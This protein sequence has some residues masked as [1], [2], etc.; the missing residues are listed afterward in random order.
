MTPPYLNV[1]LKGP[2][3]LLQHTV[4][5]L[6]CQLHTVHS[7]AIE[8]FEQVGAGHPREGKEGQTITIFQIHGLLSDPTKNL[9]PRQVTQIP[10][11]SMGKQEFRVFFANL[12]NG[13]GVIKSVN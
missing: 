3:S 1:E 5:L 10:G 13:N 6:L 9:S 2:D 12:K 7:A 4:P 11:V 8:L